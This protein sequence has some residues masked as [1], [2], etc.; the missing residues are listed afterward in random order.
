MKQTMQRRPPPAGY[1]GRQRTRIYNSVRTAL[2]RRGY[3]LINFNN[4]Q[5]E[6][7]FFTSDGYPKKVVLRSKGED[8]RVFPFVPLPDIRVQP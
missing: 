6:A 3:V 2:H 4:G 5:D 7:L 8:P 1:T